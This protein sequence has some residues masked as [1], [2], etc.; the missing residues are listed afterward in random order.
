MRRW[1]RAGSAF[2]PSTAV[3]PLAIQSRRRR[4]EAVTRERLV[5]VGSRRP[6]VVADRSQHSRRWSMRSQLRAAQRRL[7]RRDL[8]CTGCRALWYNRVIDAHSPRC[9]IDP[10]PAPRDTRKARRESPTGA[11]CPFSW[12]SGRRSGQPET[13]RSRPAASGR[14]FALPQGRGGLVWGSPPRPDYRTS[15][16]APAGVAMAARKRAY[17]ERK[18]ST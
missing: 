13:G 14:E 5:L 9:H 1:T 4:C 16:C 12:Q 8:G 11:S 10:D 18:C 7:L 3:E 2:Q 15:R 6:P 17:C